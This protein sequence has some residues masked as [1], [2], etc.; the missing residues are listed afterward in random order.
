MSQWDECNCKEV[1]VSDSA[2]GFMMMICLILGCIGGM[3]ISYKMEPDIKIEELYR[4]CLVKNIKLED[5][6]IPNK[7]LQNK[8]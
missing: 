3:I 7:P 4:F 8:E 1:E 2:T 5:C 6:K